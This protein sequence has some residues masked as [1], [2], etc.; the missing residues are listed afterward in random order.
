MGVC[1]NAWIY[2]SKYGWRLCVRVCVCVCV[3]PLPMRHPW[4][5]HLETELPIYSLHFSGFWRPSLRA[6]ELKKPECAVRKEERSEC[7]CKTNCCECRSET[8]PLMLCGHLRESAMCVYWHSLPLSS[9]SLEN[10]HAHKHTAVAVD[11]V[12]TSYGR[13]GSFL[14]GWTS[15]SVIQWAAAVVRARPERGGEGK[16]HHKLF[17]FR[18]DAHARRF[19]EKSAFNLLRTV[20]T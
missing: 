20:Q 7:L 10:T 9:V 14:P 5:C 4:I 17:T 8:Q 11:F 1:D 19:W 13:A 6:D 12:L 16:H 2:L 15:F 3:P 18:E